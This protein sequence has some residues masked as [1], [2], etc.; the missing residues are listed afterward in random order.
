[1]DFL[2]K[3]YEKILLGLVLAGLVGALVF[4]PFY[5]Q[6][7]RQKMTDLTQSIIN[8]PSIKPLTNL[9]LSVSDN[10]IDRLKNP[11]A[12]DL[13]TTNKLFN[14]GQWQ[15][16]MDGSLIPANTRTGPRVVVVTN[17]TPLYLI[18]TLDSVTTN[19][20]GARYV[21]SA[22][23]QAEKISSKRHRQAHYVSVGDKAN[24]IFG[25]VEAKGVDP[26]NPDYLLLKLT[27]T[28]ELIKISTGKPYQRVDGYS[29]DFRYDPEKKTFRGRRAGDV[30]TFDGISYIV[31]GI[32]QNELILQD[33]SN[34]K[35]TSLP[36][37]P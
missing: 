28:G 24:D 33:P 31:A 1:M 26:V 30:A 37:A 11:S 8:N 34:Q 22:E 23:R 21:I 35:K 16:A 27:D 36:F 2:K 20:F 9:D 5:I 4:M 25:L 18:L 32:N 12:I 13:D 29:A 19:E 3:H 15:K 6:A 14:P 10:A 17:I 7:D